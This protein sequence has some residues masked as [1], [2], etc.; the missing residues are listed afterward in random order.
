[1][2]KTEISIL[3]KTWS[4][5]CVEQPDDYMLSENANG[6]CDYA[7]RQ[8]VWCEQETNELS[9]SLILHELIHAYLFESGI[10]HDT[11]FHNEEAVNWISKHFRDLAESYNEYT[12]SAFNKLS[13]TEEES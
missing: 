7:K 13:K 2:N 5:E 8:I 4:V 12:D 11:L 10:A 9:V 1:M 3:G 6:Y